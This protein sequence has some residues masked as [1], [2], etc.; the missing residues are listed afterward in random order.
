MGYTVK[1]SSHFPDILD[2][3]KEGSV[4]EIA[5]FEADTSTLPC[6]V[7]LCRVPISLCRELSRCAPDL[8]LSAQP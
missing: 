2:L 7:V 4:N 5:R 1:A 6:H 8:P 3:D